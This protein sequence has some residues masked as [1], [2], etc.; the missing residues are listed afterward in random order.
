MHHLSGY[1]PTRESINKLVAETAEQVKSAMQQQNIAVRHNAFTDYC[2]ALLF[3]ATGHRPIQDPIQSKK[4]FDIEHGWMLICDKVVHE[5]RAWRIVALTKIAC[6]QLRFYAEYLPR[7]IGSLAQLEDS[8]DLIYQLN[9][10]IAG[11][12]KIPYFFYLN[13][14]K[15]TEIIN[16]T[17]SAMLKRWESHWK[18]PLNFLRHIAATEL[19]HSSNR[20]DWVQIQLGHIV[21]LNHPFGKTATESVKSMLEKI[22]PHIEQFM[23]DLGWKALRSPVRS[24]P[25]NFAAKQTNKTISRMELGHTKRTR[26]REKRRELAAPIVK[27]A[28]QEILGETRRL[29]NR[30]EFNQISQEILEQAYEQRLATNHCIK[31]LERY[32]RALKGGKAL[33]RQVARIRELEP[34]ASPFYENSVADYQNTVRIRQGFL[35]Y[36]NRSGNSAIEPTKELRIAE[37]IF[38]ASLFGGLADPHKLS[39]LS[40]SLSISTYQ[41]NKD[42]FI[43]IPLKDAEEGPVFRWFPDKVSLA[44]ILGLYEL[45]PKKFSRTKSITGYLKTLS[46]ELGLENKDTLG[47]LARIAAS[48]LTFDAPGHISACLSGTITTVSLPLPQWIR[49]QSSLALQ[50]KLKVELGSGPETAIAQSSNYP[51][52]PWLAGSQLSQSKNKPTSAELNEFNTLL[53]QFFIQSD[54]LPA[55]KNILVSTAAKQALVKAIKKEF[56]SAR[57]RQWPAMCL[58]IVSW[59]VHL[60]ER[61]TRYKKNIAFS[62]V[63]TY[64]FMVFGALKRIQP[65]GNFF[66]FDES[67]Y[68]ELYLRAL[69]SS[70][71]HSR[72]NL[73]G[74]LLEFHSYLIEAFA[75][76]EPA[77]S[78]VFSGAGQG[79][80]IS[81]ADANMVSE[82]EYLYIIET[83]QADSTLSIRLKAQ[84]IVLFIFGYRFGLRF[85]EALRIQYRDVQADTSAVCINVHNSVFGDTKSAAGIRIVPLLEKMTHLET[86]ALQQ[87][88]S[89]SQIHFQTD[90]QAPLMAEQQGSRSL[91][92]RF[93]CARDVSIYLKVLTGDNSLRY[94][95][96]RHSWATRMYAYHTESNFKNSEKNIITSSV[97]SQFWQDFVGE[98]D[99]QYP[100]RSIATA[101]GHSSETTTL[102]YYIHSIGEASHNVINLEGYSIST[103]AYSYALLIK[104]GTV[105]AR[106]SRQNLFV[107]SRKIPRPD[108]KLIKQPKIRINNQVSELDCTLSLVE[109]DW[110]LRRMSETQQ[111]IE[112][113]A[114]QLMLDQNE[115]RKVLKLAAQME[116]ESGFEFYRSDFLNKKNLIDEIY[117]L[118]LVNFFAEENKRVTDLLLLIEDTINNL[119]SLQIDTLKKGLEI[120]RKTLHNPSK[121]NVVADQEE[122]EILVES[123]N[124]I[125]PSVKHST[126]TSETYLQNSVEESNGESVKKI[127]I[128]L[129]REKTKT[130]KNNRV[131]VKFKP[132]ADIK[133]N[134][135]LCRVLFIV[136]VHLDA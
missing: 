106:L 111:D 54:N 57:V 136:G 69:E 99:C 38:S 123:I 66:S 42:L 109:T 115:A 105:R 9:S 125:A 127:S 93:I 63:R 116:R 80:Q 100:L 74:R 126:I 67:S 102:E 117:I 96:L 39:K 132:A 44:L 30:D 2:L 114:S 104:H 95:H 108:I 128:P 76:E 27:K 83:I 45:K 53:S 134:Q 129:A 103:L 20:A 18:F 1:Y 121:N 31:L 46:N 35:D 89:Y 87:V 8:N 32:I 94:H 51:D 79:E 64:V 28:L 97:I 7:L 17:P 29:P 21:G 3:C 84:Y 50:T 77:W 47:L 135:S 101:I 49:F 41:Y 118:P 122:L 37:I 24:S 16:I 88:L 78:S 120:W 91:I 19:L 58:A 60:C 5:D 113:L 112:Q 71:E 55:E 6:D 4:Y 33:L 68:E 52:S 65:D 22:S 43:D 131:V 73:A 81:Y 15:P 10:L 62:T 92:N 61:G 56:S 72:L 26:A 85:S 133:T 23:S 40:T 90:S 48:G 86:D 25:N 82:T 107:I 124:L 75:V 130:R 98:N 14:N 36:L 70:P 59:T 13:E 34:E 110:L 12:E 119:D 11:D